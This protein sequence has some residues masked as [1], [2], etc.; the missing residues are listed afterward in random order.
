MDD[1]GLGRV[2]AGA[3]TL[4]AIAIHQEADRPPVHAVDPFAHGAPLRQRVQHHPVAAQDDDD[5]RVGRGYM[6]VSAA[7]RAQ[8]RLGV[9]GRGRDKRDGNGHG[10]EG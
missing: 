6:V 4:L 7:Q 1:R 3:E 9:V 5:A 8:S 2:Q 10:G